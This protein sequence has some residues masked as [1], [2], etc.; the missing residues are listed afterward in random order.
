MQKRKVSVRLLNHDYTLVSDQPEEQVQRIARY[1]DRILRDLSLSTRSQD[2]LVPI[3]ACITLSE[4][5]FASR[6]ENNRLRREIECLRSASSENMQQKAS[7]QDMPDE[8]DR[9]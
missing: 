4:E 8:P 1:A 7:V 6:E 5:L 3:L 9:R 2:M